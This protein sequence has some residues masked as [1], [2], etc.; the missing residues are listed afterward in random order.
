[1]D[2]LTGLPKGIVRWEERY[3]A[4]VDMY[5]FGLVEIGNLGPSNFR[6]TRM[7][8]ATLRPLHSPSRNLPP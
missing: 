6:S 3:G 2:L 8:A 5:H 1:M 4:Q 7:A